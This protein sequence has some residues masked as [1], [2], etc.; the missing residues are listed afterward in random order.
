MLD[1]APSARKIRGNSVNVSNRRGQ[2]VEP[3]RK[4]RQE[5]RGTQAMEWVAEHGRAP[6]VMR[7]PQVG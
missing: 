1:S 2:L 3:I 5:V 6:P 4:D 7:F